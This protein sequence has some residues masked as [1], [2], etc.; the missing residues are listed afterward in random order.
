MERNERIVEIFV[1]MTFRGMPTQ[2]YVSDAGR[3]MSA[4]GKIRKTHLN[5]HGYEQLHIRVNKK[6]YT[7]KVHQLVGDG[8]FDNLENKKTMN[9]IAAGFENRSYNDISNLERAT[10]REQVHDTIK[11]G[12]FVGA[13]KGEKNI[14]AHHTDKQIHEV[15]KLLEQ[16]KLQISEICEL[17]GVTS[18]AVHKLVCGKTWTHISCNYNISNYTI[19]RRYSDDI[20]NTMT[21][22]YLEGVPFR[23]I[24]EQLNLPIINKI[25][26]LYYQVKKKCKDKSSTTIEHDND[27]FM[28]SDFGCDFVNTESDD[29][30]YNIIIS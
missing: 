15:C 21:K 28:I 5:N 12:T 4:N 17:T 19:G 6:D 26:C 11:K 2:Y 20:K 10:Q 24:C 8:F 3:I 7:A 13:P 14:F 22:L 16:N 9:H 25:R 18:D 23:N 1:P 30:Y 29:E 27:K